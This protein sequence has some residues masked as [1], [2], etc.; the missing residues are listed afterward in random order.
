MRPTTVICLSVCHYAGKVTR[1]G[2]SFVIVW[3]AL[4]AMDPTDRDTRLSYSSETKLYRYCEILGSETMSEIPAA[5]QAEI[6]DIVL[7][8]FPKALLPSPVQ[9]DVEMA[10]PDLHDDATSRA[11][12][13]Q[14][15]VKYVLS[16]DVQDWTHSTEAMDVMRTGA[17]KLRKKPPT[18]IGSTTSSVQHGCGWAC[19]AV[20]Y[21]RTAMLSRCRGA[22]TS[23]DTG[24]AFSRLSC[25]RCSCR[26][27]RPRRTPTTEHKGSVGTTMRPHTGATCIGKH[28]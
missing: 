17:S 13:V 15:V 8:A 11:D 3:L 7:E 12:R 14:R 26:G 24:G 5:R 28:A 21:P 23:S 1:L 10:I 2:L 16:Y 4:A 25:G 18:T 19:E 6:E 22:S 27:R 20:R 9:P